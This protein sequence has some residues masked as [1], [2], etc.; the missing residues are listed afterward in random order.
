MWYCTLNCNTEAAINAYSVFLL[1]T[2]ESKGMNQGQVLAGHM[3]MVVNFVVQSTWNK[4][5]KSNSFKV[6]SCTSFPSSDE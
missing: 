6:G 3:M 5:F 1:H 2:A 4:N